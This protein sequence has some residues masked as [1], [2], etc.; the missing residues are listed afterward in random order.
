LLLFDLKQATATRAEDDL[1]LRIDGADHH[2]IL[3]LWEFPW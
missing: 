2:I 3:A 1:L